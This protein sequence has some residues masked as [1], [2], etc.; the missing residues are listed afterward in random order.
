LEQRVAE[1]EA[2]L[3]QARAALPARIDWRKKRTPLLLLSAAILLALIP[4]LLV[5]LD[6][7]LRNRSLADLTRGLW[8]RLGPLCRSA[9]PSYFAIAFLAILALFVLV[10]ILKGN[11]L[12]RGNTQP[13]EP[14]S[15]PAAMS[16]RQA[17]TARVLILGS[18]ALLMAL[19]LVSLVRQALP[20][21]FYALAFVA[22]LLGWFL[23][24]LPAAAIADCWRKNAGWL[25]PLL[26]VTA[27]LVATL[28]SMYG[29]FRFQWFYAVLLALA[30]VNLRSHYRQVP[31]IL[32]VMLLALVLYT[33]N[34]D[35]WWLSAIGDEYA[36]FLHA[37]GV[38]ENKSLSAIG[39]LLFNGQGVYGTHPHFSSLLHAAFMWLLGVDSF[40]WRFG[41]AFLSALAV[42]LLYRFY[43]LF[44]SERVALVGA[45]LLATSHY[46]MSFGKIGYNNLQALFAMSLVLWAAAWAI[47]SSRPMAYGVAGAAAGLCFYVYPASLY[48]LPVALLLMLL[49]A[50]PTSKPAL[51][52]WG[53]MIVPLLFLL[54]P[55]A[56]QP[57]Y[58]GAK[59][60]GTFFYRPELVQ[61][62]G[63]LL[64]HLASNMVY[65]L[66]SFLYAPAEGL[67]V[68]SSFVDPITG[69]L[70]LIG[71][72][73]LL[74]CLFDGGEGGTL[75]LVQ[76]C[77]D[78]VP[79]RGVTRS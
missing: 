7:W 39:P 42:G 69:A 37:R 66:F 54:L 21:W 19:G 4:S 14:D 41:N 59:L 31:A 47:R 53:L 71:I 55:L 40:G 27:A 30:L 26:L 64:G 75:P 6:R 43:K 11:R 16:G 61:T 46:I 70:V 62:E 20:G 35:A 29:S 25:M 48:I 73:Y 77:L 52:R 36:F 13:I 58:W 28:A 45:F 78:G 18:A 50:P 23:R 1:L 2:Q 79:G 68:A 72:A 9:L 15:G 34:Q 60:P 12:F 22:Y 57:E 76:F 24:E 17:A 8:C 56:V 10:W 38:V 51:R 67:F 49:Y 33:V 32:W 74:R 65:A 44:V 3:A 5:F 63:A